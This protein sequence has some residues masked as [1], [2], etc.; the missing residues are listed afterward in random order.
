MVYVLF[1]LLWGL[2]YNRRGV[3]YQL[4]LKVDR[5]SKNDLINV[6]QQLVGRLNAL[7]GQS[8]T[9][10]LSLKRK[11]NLFEGATMAYDQLARTEGDFKY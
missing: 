1:N 11:R 10:R 6:M 3:A 7:D 2:N 9:N 5:Y 4:G 8:R